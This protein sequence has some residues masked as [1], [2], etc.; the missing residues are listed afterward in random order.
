L[1]KAITGFDSN[2]RK[3]EITFE[4][5][6]LDS[7]EFPLNT[8]INMIFNVYWKKAGVGAVSHMSVVYRLTVVEPI[9]A[10]VKA[11]T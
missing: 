5:E 2:S 10:K 1:N 4:E 3:F 11:S 8:P 9:V 7:K 6:V